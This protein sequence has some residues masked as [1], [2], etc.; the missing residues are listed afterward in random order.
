LV[1]ER[2]KSTGLPVIGEELGG[3]PALFESQELY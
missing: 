1:R 2:L 3:D